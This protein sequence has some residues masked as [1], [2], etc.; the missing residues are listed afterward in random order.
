MEITREDYNSESEVLLFING[1]FP[2]RLPYLNNFQKIY[3]VDGA[4]RHLEK[5]GIKPDVLSGDF[6]SLKRGEIS[7][8]VK[9]IET[10][11]Q[12]FTDFEKALQLII[13]DGYHKIAVYGCSGLEQDHF[14]GNIHSMVKHKEELSIRCFDDYG[15]Y[16]F[17]ENET[18]ITGFKEQ[19]LSLFPFPQVEKITSKGVKY[20]LTRESLSLITRIGARNTITETSA[21]ITF[22]SGNLL[23]FVQN[24]TD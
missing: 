15:F 11:N 20:P 5:N 4:Y 2:R 7:S 24:R 10:P 23:I 13:K 8:D 21:K 16:F 18:L 1:Q 3:C 17:A 6:D 22:E 9:V 19:T 12:E 14:L